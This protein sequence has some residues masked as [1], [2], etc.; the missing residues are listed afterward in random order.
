ME[1]HKAIMLTLSIEGALLRRYDPTLIR[2]RSRFGGL[3][4]PR[5]EGIRRLRSNDA[6]KLQTLRIRK[7]KRGKEN[8]T[9]PTWHERK[10][11]KVYVPHH[12]YAAGERW[13]KKENRANLQRIAS[14]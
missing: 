12:A 10:Y 4:T 2:T 9:T 11:G 5:N 8:K 6:L 7:S 1:S 13:F 14:S 3:S